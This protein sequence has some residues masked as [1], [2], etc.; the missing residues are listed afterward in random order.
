MSKNLRKK[1]IIPKDIDFSYSDN[2]RT[3]TLKGPLGSVS[4]VIPNFI[5]I[6]SEFLDDNT[7]I[8]L[9]LNADEKSSRKSKEKDQLALI[10]TF[11]SLLSN[12][13]LGI[14]KGHEKILEVRNGVGYRIYFDPEL[15]KITF[16]LGFS[17][18]KILFVPE[19]IIFNFSNNIISIKGYD[20]WLVGSF[21][22]KI[23]NLRKCSSYKIKGI[24]YK[25]EIVKPK[26]GKTVNK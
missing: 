15:K 4:Q 16:N 9:N 23:R 21:S 8:S 5:S 10:G 19:G 17:H 12:S 18:P 3:L 22:H 13:I 25:D 14:T 24:Y 11:N 20:K 2:D 1:I 6:T 26:V 7:L